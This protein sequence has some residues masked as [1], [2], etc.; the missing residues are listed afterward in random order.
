MHIRISA[1]A[2]ISAV[3]VCDCVQQRVSIVLYACQREHVQ[4]LLEFMIA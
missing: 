4:A 3:T 1:Q 2:C